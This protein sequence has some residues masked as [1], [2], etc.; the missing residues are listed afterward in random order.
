MDDLVEPGPKEIRLPG[1][2]T[3][4]RPHESPRR[5]LDETRGSRSASQIK[6]QENQ[7]TTR[8]NQQTRTLP[9]SRKSP[10][11]KASGVLHARLSNSHEIV[12]NISLKGLRVSSGQHFLPTRLACFLDKCS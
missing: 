9:E 11:I 10:Q 4:L 12:Q 2:P 8:A 1:L 3:L 7:S 5:H 6:L